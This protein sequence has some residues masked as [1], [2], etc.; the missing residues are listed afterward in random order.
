MAKRSRK[1]STK[2]PRRSKSSSR[3]TMKRTKQQH[4]KKHTLKKH[5]SKKHTLKKPKKVKRKSIRK[6]KKTKKVMKGGDDDIEDAYY[7]HT[8]PDLEEL[9]KDKPNYSY[10]VKKASTTT[11]KPYMGD[12]IEHL[13]TIILKVNEKDLRERKTPVFSS[14]NL[15]IPHVKIP[16]NQL[17]STR[18][19]KIGGQTKERF[20]TA[21]QLI[22]HYKTNSIDNNNNVKLV[23]P[24]SN[25]SLYSPLD[26]IPLD[27]ISSDSS[28]V[29][30]PV[31]KET[32]YGPIGEGK[33]F[34][35]L[36]ELAKKPKGNPQEPEIKQIYA[37]AYNTSSNEG[38][39]ESSNSEL[40]I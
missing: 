27:N 24:I 33:T 15:H 18:L 4:S 12:S 25:N 13:Y 16:I 8:D 39:P 28:S 17:Q 29:Y 21:L 20:T 14:D 7:F 37:E 32:E 1:V 5:S 9:L 30:G 38:D 10:Y 31:I 19:F 36:Q 35:E 34:K 26:N 6:R 2:R 22:E 40:D 3:K 11:T 23:N